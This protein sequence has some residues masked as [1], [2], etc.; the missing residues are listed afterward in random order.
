MPEIFTVLEGSIAAI[1]SPHKK[2]LPDEHNRYAV[3]NISSDAE[4]YEYYL[5]FVQP[6]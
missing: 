6:Y 3:T 4:K 1:I 5:P 2:L